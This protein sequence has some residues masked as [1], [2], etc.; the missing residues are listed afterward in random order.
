MARRSKGPLVFFRKVRR[1]ATKARPF[2]KPAGN[3]GRRVMVV[4]LRRGIATLS[5]VT[6]QS[7]AAVA[8]QAARLG[9]F[10]ALKAAQRKVPVGPTGRLRASLNAR[11]RT[12]TF[13]TVG[14]NV[15]Y[16]K[17]VERGTR[18]GQIIRPKRGKLLAFH[19]ANAPAAVRRRFRG[20]GR[21]SR[22]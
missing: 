22:R 16:G 17:W 11:R 4:Q 13:W 7:V 6:K 21:G 8:A 2:L 14:T 15:V 10:A 12:R 3:I 5:T 18:G 9:T 1:A 20:R 19:W